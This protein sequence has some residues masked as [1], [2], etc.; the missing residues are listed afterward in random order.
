MHRHHYAYHPVG[1]PVGGR[2]RRPTHHYH[3]GHGILGSLWSIAKPLI[4]KYAPVVLNKAKEI[5]VAEGKKALERAQQGV[6]LK[7]VLK[8]AAAGSVRQGKAEAL[9]VAKNAL[10]DAAT[11]V[12]QPNPLKE[13]VA[14]GSG[15]AGRGR[16]RGRPKKSADVLRITKTDKEKADEERKG[17]RALARAQVKAGEGQGLFLL[18]Q[19][20]HV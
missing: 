13:S 19:N 4:Q 6:P 9:A 1:G 20:A 3:V 2:R 15:Y 7:Q 10:V 18:G 17:A 11:A 16:G 14:Q 12:S 5:A 8:E